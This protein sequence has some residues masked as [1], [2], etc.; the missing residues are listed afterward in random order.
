MGEARVL[1]ATTYSAIREHK[2]KKNEVENSLYYEYKSNE[3][4]PGALP[5]KNT[6][7]RSG[8]PFL[9]PVALTVGH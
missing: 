8:S 2:I 5:P 4:H 3:I 9:V 6:H 1:G 7:I